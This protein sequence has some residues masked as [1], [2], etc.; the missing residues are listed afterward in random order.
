MPL[1]SQAQGNKK[2]PVLVFL[3]GFLGDGH[4]W[5]D[6]INHLKDSYYC[7]CLDLPGH[8]RSISLP[9]LQDGF[10]YCHR[11]IR[12][13]LAELQIKD[14]SLIGYSLGGRIALDYA[15]TQEDNNLQNLMLESSHIGLA[16][17]AEKEQRYQ[18][19][20]NWARRFAT[21]SVM[22]SLSKWYEQDIFHDLSRQKKD[23]L[24]NKR[25]HNYG[26]FVA[27]M[28]LSTSLARQHN[29]RS[30]LQIN[31]MHNKPL[32]IYYCVGEKDNKFKK[33]A[34]ALSSL[35]KINVTEFK[36]A[37]HNIHQQQPLQYAQ[38][39]KEQFTK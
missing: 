20:L 19:D 18:D 26:V 35:K 34:E 10:A 14:Y 21:Q 5:T 6:T 15:R 9:P 39:I 12:D 8:G 17:S 25:R 28:L 2:N 33:I 32:A 24:I 4:D 3:H 31:A 11:L 29:A 23:C 13:A 37:G 7:I 1:F 22:Q 16:T 30:F 38:F 36:G 27:G